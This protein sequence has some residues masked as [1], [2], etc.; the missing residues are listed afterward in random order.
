MEMIKLNLLERGEAVDGEGVG[1]AAVEHDL[2]DLVDVEPRRCV[3]GGELRRGGDHVH[4][5]PRG[6]Q[7]PHHLRGERKEDGHR[8]E[9]GQKG[10]HEQAK[11]SRRREGEPLGRGWHAQSHDR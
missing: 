4:V 8:Q 7:G 5:V 9:T 10:S 3:L 6:E 2:L 1:G 11:E